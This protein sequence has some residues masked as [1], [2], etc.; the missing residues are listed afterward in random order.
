MSFASTNGEKELANVS[1][2]SITSLTREQFGPGDVP[3]Q[4]GDARLVQ[5]EHDG[6]TNGKL[7]LVLGGCRR[8]RSPQAA[9]EKDV[10]VGGGRGQFDRPPTAE[11][12]RMRPGFVGRVSRA[13]F[14]G[15]W[16]RF[17]PNARDF[18]VAKLREVR[19]KMP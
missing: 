5:L 3:F 9:A 8:R 11:S 12:V 7:D 19:A 16:A 18:H 10:A 13:S 1:K 4:T 15:N 2:Q 17:E 6:G 14:V